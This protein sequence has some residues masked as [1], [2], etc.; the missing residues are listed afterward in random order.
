MNDRYKVPGRTG[1]WFGVDQPARPSIRKQTAVR[2][3]A[4]SNPALSLH[5]LQKKEPAMV[6]DAPT[7]VRRDHAYHVVAEDYSYKSEAYYTILAHELAG[8]DVRPCSRA[9]LD[10]FVVPVCLERAS[11]ARY[12]SRSVG[13]FA[14]VRPS[15]G[16]T[17]WSQLLRHNFRLYC[18]A[19]YHACKRGYQT[20]YQ[21]GQ[22]PL[23]LPENR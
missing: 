22:V 14:R 4:V 1:D 20:Y 16:N 12:S 23:L 17:V 19:G 8:D 9:V 2:E 10:A 6:R 7:V 13:N 5:L 11:H 3:A 15:P 18:S 21:H